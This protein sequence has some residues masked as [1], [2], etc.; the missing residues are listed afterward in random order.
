MFCFWGFLPCFGGYFTLRNSQVLLKFCLFVFFLQMSM[1][2]EEIYE[3]VHS[4]LLPKHKHLKVTA[5]PRTLPNIDSKAT[6]DTGFSNSHGK[7]CSFMK[8]TSPTW[9]GRSS[10]YLF[11]SEPRSGLF[12]RGI[13]YSSNI[14]KTKVIHH[15]PP[16]R[17]T[18][19]I[20]LSK[21]TTKLYIL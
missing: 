21:Q 1:K 5:L 10:A 4:I 12:P 8:P 20:S 19:S 9:V 14:H 13:I 17:A 16:G 7:I 15:L 3:Y 18:E 11:S 2:V 6:R